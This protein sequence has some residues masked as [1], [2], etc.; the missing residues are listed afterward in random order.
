M[1]KNRIHS[2]KRP[3][4]TKTIVI[5]LLIGWLVTITVGVVMATIISSFGG[6]EKMLGPTSVAGTILAS[7]ITAWIITGAFDKNK[8]LFSLLGGVLYFVSLMCINIIFYDGNYE[9]VIYSLCMIL[10]SSTAVGLLFTR[11][12]ATKIRR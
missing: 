4:I 5:G 2:K 3:S 6:N 11:K 10:G 7:M 8:L 1:Y 9:G 12:R